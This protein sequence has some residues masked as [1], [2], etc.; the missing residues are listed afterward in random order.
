MIALWD[1]APEPQVVPFFYFKKIVASGLGPLWGDLREG[2]LAEMAQVFDE[3][4]LALPA[5]VP[6]LS[7]GKT[8]VHSE[9]MG[10]I[11]TEMQYLQRAFPGGAW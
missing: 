10:Y 6:F 11:L 2:W 4:G 8:G 1:L 5:S 9:H 7:T 3:A